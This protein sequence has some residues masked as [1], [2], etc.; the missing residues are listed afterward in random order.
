MVRTHIGEHLGVGTVADNGSRGL[1]PKHLTKEEFAR[2]VYRL[3]VQRGWTQ[4]DLAR[5]AGLPR[6][7]ISVYVR[8]KSLPTPVN[9][10]KLAACFGMKAEELLPNIV[11]SAI[12]N[13]QPAFEMRASTAAPGKVW[14]RV[15][16]LVSMSTAVKIA[17]LLEQDDSVLG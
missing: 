6:D 10:A 17:E 5:H 8:A 7:A 11:E 15:N 13:D 4:S 12:D 14:L 1:T 16:R 9:L 3:M 2:R